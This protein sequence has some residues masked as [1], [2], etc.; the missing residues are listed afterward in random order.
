MQL[1]IGV[2]EGG[3]QVL[4]AL[5][6]PGVPQQLGFPGGQGQQNHGKQGTENAHPAQ[7]DEVGIGLVAGGEAA[8]GVGGKGGKADAQGRS[9]GGFGLVHNG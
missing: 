1:V 6:A 8:A 5:A 7:R 2:I 4:V 9:P 3:K